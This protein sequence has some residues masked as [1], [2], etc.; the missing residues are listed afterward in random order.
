MVQRSDS[1]ST[2]GEPASAARPF[3]FVE[4][5]R[6]IS[7]FF[8]GTDR[9]HQAMRTVARVFDENRIAYAIIGGMAVNAHGHVRTTGDVDFLVR[10]EAMPAIRALTARSVFTG[11]PGRP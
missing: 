7:M 4:R 3:S 2:M 10:S 1:E 5:L 6:E 11:V 9:V 8:D